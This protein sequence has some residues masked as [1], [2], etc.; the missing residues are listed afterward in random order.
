[1]VDG[2]TNKKYDLYF[3]EDVEP[4]YYLNT[5]MMYIFSPDWELLQGKPMVDHTEGIATSWELAHDSVN[6]LYSLYINGL[7]FDEED[8]MYISGYINLALQLNHEF[9]GDLH[10][11]PARIYWDST[12]FCTFWI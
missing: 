10:K 2:D 5:G 7:S 1:M 11:Y 4:Y 9:G 3:P 8:N 12:N 6:P